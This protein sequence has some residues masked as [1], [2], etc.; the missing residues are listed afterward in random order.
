LSVRL[1]PRQAGLFEKSCKEVGETPT[2]LV[3]RALDLLLQPQSQ[4]AKEDSA[5]LEAVPMPRPS[6]TFPAALQDLLPGFYHFGTQLPAERRRCF[7][8]LL[9]AS[10]VLRQSRRGQYDTDLCR[11]LLSIGK[12]FGLM[13]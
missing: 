2:K 5:S 11:Q 13:P 10:E 12:Q 9:A 4:G 7:Q 8:R 1:E 3:R 6:Y